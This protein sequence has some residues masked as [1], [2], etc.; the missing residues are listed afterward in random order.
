MGNME[1]Y[2][3]EFLLSLYERQSEIRNC[4]NRLSERKAYEE[5]DLKKVNKAIGEIEYD[6]MRKREDE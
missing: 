3:R 1:E 2:Q 4:L 5:E 6:L